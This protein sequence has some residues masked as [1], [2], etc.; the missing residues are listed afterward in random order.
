MNLLDTD[1]DSQLNLLYSHLLICRNLKDLLY[2][3]LPTQEWVVPLNF[4][5]GT[6]GYPEPVLLTVLTRNSWLE[7]L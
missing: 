7:A 3:S 4:S 2:G 6:T 1:D 5:T